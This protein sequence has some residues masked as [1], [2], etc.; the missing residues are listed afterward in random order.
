[1]CIEGEVLL[2]LQS[3]CN[4]FPL[5]GDFLSAERYGSGH[6]N[7]TYK[8]TYNL[9]GKPIHY[10]LQRINHTVFTKPVEVQENIV[11]VTEHLAAKLP[12][13]D[14]T[15]RTLTLLRTRDGNLPYFH[16]E[17]GYWRIYLFV[18][19]ASSHDVS[20]TPAQTYQAARAFAEFQCN[21]SD[22]PA[23]RLHET[24]PGFH[25][26]EKRYQTF[27]EA[28]EKD[29]FNRAAT[30]KE[31]IA[32]L[33]ARANLCGRFNRLLAEGKLPERITHN[34]TKINNVLLNDITG[35]G[36]CVIDL[37]T[38]MPGLALN[39]FGDMCRTG[40]AAAA[41][42]EQ[43]L[44]KVACRLDL[45]EA[46]AKG[47]CSKARN[48]LN[49]TER[50][51]LAFAPRLITQT[52]GIRF[53]TDYLNGDTYFKTHRPGHNLDRFRTQMQMVLD[54]EAKSEEMERI[55]QN[56]LIED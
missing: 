3:V 9:A 55:I 37:D 48:F 42:D 26:T 21:L 23:P 51:E 14:R 56:A 7:D 13:G 46:M 50:A 20:E 18:E 38:V 8:V 45:F 35:E 33:E 41:E 40:T 28:L 5:Y 53:L 11:C 17:Q 31:E 12:S 44:S 15:N 54:M 24:I 52:I 47:Y 10:L 2:M 43:D 4:A 22:L 19:G 49:D 30:C 36:Q 27:L 25:D 1:M 34:D 32:F 6:I 29:A 39:D 16:N